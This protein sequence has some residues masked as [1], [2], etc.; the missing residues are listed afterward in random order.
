VLAPIETAAVGVADAASRNGLR[1][2]AILSQDALLPRAVVKGT[3]E[4]AKARGPELISTETHPDGTTDFSAILN[5][6]N[7]RHAAS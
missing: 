3:G 2:V 7:L 4:V 1:T 5:R 6:L